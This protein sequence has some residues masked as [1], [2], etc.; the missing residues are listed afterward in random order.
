M[1]WC[2]REKNILQCHYFD[3]GY[4]YDYDLTGQ[5]KTA[6]YIQRAQNDENWGESSA[7]NERDIEYDKNG[8]I[9]QMKRTDSTGNRL[10]DLA[11]IYRGNQLI[12]FSCNDQVY[13]GYTY[14]ASGNLTYDPYSNSTMN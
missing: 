3:A 9:L 5:L 8:N 12:S 6:A 13:E 11:Y 7:F 10:H 14:D 2:C 1:K 4:K